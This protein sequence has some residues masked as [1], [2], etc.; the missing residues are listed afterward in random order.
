MVSRYTQCCHYLQGFY[1]YFLPQWGAVAAGGSKSFE[2]QEEH[3]LVDDVSFCGLQQF[4]CLYAGCQ[5]SVCVTVQL[6]I[7]NSYTSK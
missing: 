6:I 7:S 2:S 4:F 5:F 1:T 3:S